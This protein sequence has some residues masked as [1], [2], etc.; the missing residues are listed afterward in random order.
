MHVGLI[1]GIGPAATEFYY[2]HITRVHAR[3]ARPLELTMVHAQIADLARN[4]TSGAREAQAVIF[5]ALARRLQAA[6]ADLVAVTSVAG[7]FCRHEFEAISP[8]PVVSIVPAVRAALE[9]RG[10]RR[11]GLLG[12]GVAMTTRVYGELEGFEVLV[13]SGEDFALVDREYVA[14]ATAAEATDHHRDVFFGAGRE[15][16]RRGADTVLLAGTDLFLAFEGHECGFPT[17][18]CARAHVE[19]ITAR[20]LA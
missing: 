16:C 5:A 18:D 6:G 2:R 17:V 4:F 19:A 7:H 20:S 10:C 8:L 14:M 9:A 3:E 12:T 15:L 13:P 11:I 1:G